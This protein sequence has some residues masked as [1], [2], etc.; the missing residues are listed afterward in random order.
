MSQ[1]W[2]FDDK[3]PARVVLA[4]LESWNNG[5]T[6]TMHALLDAK[7]R[8]RFPLERLQFGFSSQ[9][10]GLYKPNVLWVRVTKQ[11]MKQGMKYAIVDFAVRPNPRSL[12]CSNQS[13][14]EVFDTT[15]EKGFGFGI[16]KDEQHKH[17]FFLNLN[18]YVLIKE[19]DGW[20][21]TNA[22]SEGIAVYE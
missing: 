10:L 18:R 16:P 17:F 7:T 4:F 19:T 1:Q 22:I 3:D 6:K 5:D 14:P 8:E 9:L 12:F 15:I 20:R 2:V 13:I 11:G 21:I